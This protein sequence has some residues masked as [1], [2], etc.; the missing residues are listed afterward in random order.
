MRS[1]HSDI[2]F[3]IVVYEKIFGS[4]LGEA[5][6]CWKF[7]NIPYDGSDIDRFSNSQLSM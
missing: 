6:L 2:P 3:I 7:S 4:I 1:V 5:E